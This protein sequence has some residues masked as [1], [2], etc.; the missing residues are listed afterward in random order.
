MYMHKNLKGALVVVL[1]LGLGA[2]GNSIDSNKTLL[3]L[4]PST[5]N[6]I[7]NLGHAA[8]STLDL[9]FDLNNATLISAF[10]LD[11]LSN[12]TASSVGSIYNDISSIN[13]AKI[14]NSPDVETVTMFYAALGKGGKVAEAKLISQPD[15]ETLLSI[16]NTD[17]D[18]NELQTVPP[19]LK[20]IYLGTE[21]SKEIANT[22]VSCRKEYAD[23]LN[24][25]GVNSRYIEK[26]DEI[27]PTDLSTFEYDDS[28][29]PK[30]NSIAYVK[31]LDNGK[32]Q[33]VISAV[34]IYFGSIM[35]KRS[36]VLDH[37]KATS[38]ESYEKAVRNFSIRKT[39]YHEF[40]HIL[41]ESVRQVNK[42]SGKYAYF[43][44][45]QTLESATPTL[46]KFFDSKNILA[47]LQT[48]EAIAEA[49]AE[50]L[51]F[52]MLGEVYNL[53]PSQK[54]ALWDHEFGRL[55]LN[56]E[57]INKI[58]GDFK[59]DFADGD[60]IDLSNRLSELAFDLTGPKLSF[61][62]KKQISKLVNGGFIPWLGY[63]NPTT[64]AEDNKMF[65]F[66]KDTHL[67]E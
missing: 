12:Y 42:G 4:V 67:V 17:K 13:R 18:N 14:A 21:V 44:K 32:K 8:N 56:R 26:L 50:G 10:G 1:S 6:N 40:T 16:I 53:S 7:Q 43:A 61:A 58:A 66:L 64:K 33:F 20:N 15:E 9:E 49:Q 57:R 23:Y 5:T 63:L 39:C 24:F 60:L 19:E 51:S 65:E 54:K 30:K 59:N 55:V 37:L 3:P 34:H 38:P 47:T 11:D 48:E 22:L 41:Q 36:G 2:C 35:Y 62:D 28:N 52:E 29:D 45:G 25:R 46:Q 27:F 31:N